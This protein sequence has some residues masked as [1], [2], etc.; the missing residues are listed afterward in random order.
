M[1][2]QATAPQFYETKIRYYQCEKMA[3][4]AYWLALFCNNPCV[5]IKG[6]KDLEKSNF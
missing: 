4:G 6:V 1:A 2:Q 5:K 3:N